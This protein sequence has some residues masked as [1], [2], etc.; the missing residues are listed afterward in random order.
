[1]DLVLRLFW[2]LAYKCIQSKPCPLENEGLFW[3]SQ[4]CRGAILDGKSLTVQTVYVSRPIKFVFKDW[5]VKSL[6]MIL[7][8]K[9]AQIAVDLA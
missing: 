6:T 7:V 9:A 2:R 1:M 8:F 4:I 5:V 3:I